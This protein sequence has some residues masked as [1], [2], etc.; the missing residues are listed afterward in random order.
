VPGLCIVY[1]SICLT[2]EEKS[3]KNLSQ[4][5]R[6]ALGYSVL[7]AIRLVD[8]VIAGDDLDYPA[9][10]CRPWL[11]RQ[12]T[13]STLGQPKNLPSCRTRSFPKSATFESKLAVS[14]LI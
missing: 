14:A 13:G 1:P 11:T 12:A 4:A 6:K 7:N 3:P 2:T 5:S 10:P 9:G 8:V